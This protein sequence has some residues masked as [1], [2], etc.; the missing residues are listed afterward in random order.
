MVI[1]NPRHLV[2]FSKDNELSKKTKPIW[3]MQIANYCLIC[4]YK[5]TIMGKTFGTK[6]RNPVKL[7]KKRKL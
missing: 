4:C 5:T 7:D 2:S 1:E 3:A 6:Q